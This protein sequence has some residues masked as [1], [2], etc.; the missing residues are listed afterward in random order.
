MELDLDEDTGALWHA[1]SQALSAEALQQTVAGL[2][3]LPLTRRACWF[4][5][6]YVPAPLL[7]LL[8]P[9][10]L[11]RP[12]PTGWRWEAMPPS[13]C[14]PEGFVERLSQRLTAALWCVAG[15]RLR[16]DVVATLLERWLDA[17]PAYAQG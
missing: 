15:E 13:V 8:Q 3:V 4:P 7:P 12:R 9:Y 5:L 16:P 17:E 14:L 1:A 11:E 10:L 6:H 2:A